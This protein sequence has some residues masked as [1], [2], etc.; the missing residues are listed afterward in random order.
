MKVTRSIAVCLVVGW[1]STISAV[2]QYWP[3]PAKTPGVDVKC[4]GC[5]GAASGLLTP[6]YPSAFT[7]FTGRYLD[8]QATND[9]QQPFRT[10]RAF[11]V[12]P[13][14]SRNRIYMIIG[15]AVAAYNM[16]T[17]FTRIAANEP[18]MSANSVPTSGP[19]S[20]SRHPEPVDKFL[21]WDQ[22]FYAE[23]EPNGWSLF[24]TDGQDRLFDIDYDDQGYVYMAYSTYGWGIAKD[25]GGTGGGLMESQFQDTAT[26]P[27]SVTPVQVA[28]IKTAD[29]RYWAVVGGASANNN[30]V[31]I[32]DVTDRKNPI[33]GP[34]VRTTMVAHAR[35]STADRI[36]ILTIDNKLQIYSSDG[37][38]AG[39]QP[40]AEFPSVG[41]ANMRGVAS[42]GTNFFATS[43]VGSGMVISVFS[44]TGNT[45]RRVGDY[46]TA[47]T[48]LTQDLRYGEGYLTWSGFT[49]GLSNLRLFKLQNLV[50]S[51]I[52]VSNYF[53]KYYTG[54]AG[55]GYTHPNFE[56]FWH[57]GAVVKK[58]GKTYL[59][60]TAYG[61][62]DVYELPSTDS[63]TVANL[64]VSGTA[65]TKLPAD[66]GTGPFPGDPIAFQAT[67]LAAG[68]MNIV[69]DYGDG[70]T[71]PGTTGTQVK[72]QYAGAVLGGANSRSVVVKA[73]NATD[74]SINSSTSVNLQKPSVR[75]GV[76]NYKYLFVQPNASSPAPIVVGDKFFDASDGT[77]ESHF[78]T[79]AIDT[80]APVTTV[81]PGQ[82]DV[83][84]CGQH[85]LVFDA[86]YGPYNPST[87]T[88]SGTDFPIG[89]HS[90]TYAARPFAAAIDVT[91][92]TL[93]VT[94]TSLSRISSDASALSPSQAAALTYKWE[95]LDGSNQPVTAAGSPTGTAAG[96]VVPPFLVSKSLFTGGNFRAHLILTS[97]SG[98]GTG[99]TAFAAAEAFTNPLNAPDPVITG[100]CTG[101]NNGPPCS[102]TVGSTSGQDTSAWTYAWTVSPNDGTVTPSTGNGKTFQPS[103]TK[104]GTYTVS[105]TVANSIN[106]RSASTSPFSVPGSICQT[107]QPGISIFISYLGGTS[108][109]SQNVG[110]CSP[111]ETV[112]FNAVSFTGYDFSC[113]NH[114]FSWNFGDNTTAAVK[115]PT[116]VYSSPGTYTVSLTVNNGSQSVQMSQTV[117]VAGAP[118]PPP[119][120]PPPPSPTGCA[121]MSETN[122]FVSY[123][124]SSSGCTQAGGTCAAGETITLTVSGFGY[125]FSCANHTFSWDFGASGKTVTHA[126]SAT[127]AV[128]VTISNG[129]QVFQARA[130]IP[131]G[132][133]T[134][135]PPTGSC[136]TMNAT[137]VF[138]SYSGPSSGCTQ[139]GGNCTAGEQVTLTVS[140][141]GY[142]FAC[143]NHTFTW[144]FGGSGRT[145]THAFTS[146]TPVSVTINNGPQTFTASAT[147]PISGST[148]PPPPPPPGGCGTLVPGTS[149]FVSYAG[150]QS[151]CTAYN[152]SDCTTTETIPF[153][154]S[155]FNY[156]FNCATHT[157][158]W[159]FG[160]GTPH[161]GGRSTTHQY[162]SAGAFPLKLIISVSGQNYVVTQTVKV[163]GQSPVTSY[164]FDF[165]TQAIPGLPNTYKF[166]AFATV[167]GASAAVYN[168]DFGDGATA[169]GPSASQIHQYPDDKNY[170]VTLSVAGYQGNVQHKVQDKVR[171][172]P[173]VHP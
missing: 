76:G 140:G 58:N 165:T 23:N 27:D 133:G 115:N 66:A 88:S 147:V 95:L 89:I 102:F 10:A 123:A 47:K 171:H 24:I 129:S 107:I 173:S 81:P 155:P 130:N 74:S 159:D 156:D 41:G 168:W 150:P 104:A 138:I 118:P 144:S 116:H 143:A 52:D 128:A 148:P 166:T 21:N 122:V 26:S 33:R 46:P 158:D 25:S 73:T 163:A 40:L 15:S 7:S 32:F 42:D 60:A 35:N 62:G 103:F 65:N 108:G 36:A 99:C 125:D 120:P 77:V 86:H 78:N 2:A 132:S 22:F 121:T 93:S 146:T 169:S 157:F 106:S 82:V 117:I 29:G 51:E 98:V 14:P 9:F 34:S 92:D 63:V 85:T 135:P 50:P 170:Q 72:H 136:A 134:Q 97:P 126:F 48:G 30:I 68:G 71:A 84:A 59:F 67:T 56:F 31:N 114:T 90:L 109:C 145:V 3:L 12:L 112:N 38:V 11:M 80:A 105:V 6:G 45:Y 16:D 91:S 142:D 94:F 111:G 87:I 172:R 153:T 43:D 96:G 154:A 79:W 55:S 124:G 139:A 164:Q 110:S 100:G 1:L 141:F 127:T 149:V 13:A 37:L 5:L 101:A 53:Q 70:T 75:F 17:F 83:G 161:G 4:V 28:S 160:D 119:P 162:V 20:S 19:Y 57:A 44:P 69:W 49:S 8:S 167:A 152:N 64:G 18:L 151:G 137:N 54:T 131:V 61:L 39:R 113:A